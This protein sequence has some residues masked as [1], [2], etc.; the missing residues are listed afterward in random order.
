[1]AND[2]TAA[3]SVMTTMTVVLLLEPTC[4]GMVGAG[5]VVPPRGFQI[6]S[7]GGEDG[8]NG[9]GGGGGSGGVGGG[10]GGANT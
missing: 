4:I 9:G 5:G 6:M 3:V 10:D 8:D 2:T 7:N 1:M